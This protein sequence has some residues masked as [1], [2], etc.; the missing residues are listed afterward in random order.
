[1]HIRVIEI[2][3]NVYRI[4]FIKFNSRQIDV[5]RKVTIRKDSKVFTLSYEYRRFD[6]KNCSL[7]MQKNLQSMMCLV[8]SACLAYS[9][10]NSLNIYL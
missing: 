6:H 1:M 2:D 7:Y 5:L 3:V 9:R 4:M 8:W 10:R